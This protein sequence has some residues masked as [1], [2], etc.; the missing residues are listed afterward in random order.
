[1]AQHLRVT[2]N[3]GRKVEVI[4]SPKAQ[5]QVER[6]FKISLADDNTRRVEH[7]YFLAWASL[8]YAGQEPNDF[9][10]FLGSIEDVE[11]TDAVEPD[12]T[13]ADPSSDGSFSS[14]SQPTAPSTS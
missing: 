8:H 5:V 13:Q 6:H 12:P 2:Y 11:V 1:M 10:N 9:E 14:P 3:D 7:V 4:A